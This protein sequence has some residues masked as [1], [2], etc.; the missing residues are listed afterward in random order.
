M[1]GLPAELC[2]RGQIGSAGALLTHRVKEPLGLVP[3]LEGLLQSMVLGAAVLLKLLQQSLELAQL[4][5]AAA[6]ADAF[7][8]GEEDHQSPQSSHRDGQEKQG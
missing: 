1:E 5:A 2:L 3:L 6:V 7:Y 8:D 4:L